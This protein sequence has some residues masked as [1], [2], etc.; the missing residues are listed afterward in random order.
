TIRAADKSRRF[1]SEVLN[2]SEQVIAFAVS[3]TGI[4][5]PKDKQRL[6]FEAFQQADGSTNRKYGGTGLGLSISREIARL[7]GGEI[8]VESTAGAGSTFT[9]F[10]PDR[11]AG[12]LDGGEEESE[13]AAAPAAYVPGARGRAVGAR[14]PGRSPAGGACPG[15]AA[16]VAEAPVR[17]DRASSEDGERV[18]L[19]IETDARFARVLP[20]MAREKGFRGIVAL[21]GET[22]HALAEEY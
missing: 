21:D 3:D 16:A 11:F 18:V 10:L 6:I 1:A 20:A 12:P 15:G 7:L 9:L 17:A 22:G 13:C 5:I 14:R 8:R 19:I 2:N 4:G